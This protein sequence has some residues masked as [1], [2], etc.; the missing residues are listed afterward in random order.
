MFIGLNT[1]QFKIWKPLIKSVQWNL[2]FATIFYSIIPISN[3]V[4]LIYFKEGILL[5]EIR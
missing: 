2:V 4:D 5:D 1:E 3:I